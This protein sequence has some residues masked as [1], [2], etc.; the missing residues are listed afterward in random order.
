M[1]C[2]CMVRQE[3]LGVFRWGEDRNGE[4]RQAR[5]GQLR[6]GLMRKDW[7]GITLMK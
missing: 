5:L 3:R 1:F 6:N 2:Y 4:E 7:L